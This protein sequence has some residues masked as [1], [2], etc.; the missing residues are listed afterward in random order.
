[1]HRIWTFFDSSYNELKTSKKKW[2]LKNSST[3]HK[4]SCAFCMTRVFDSIH[5]DFSFFHGSSSWKLKKVNAPKIIVSSVNDL[6]TLHLHKHDSMIGKWNYWLDFVFFPSFS[7]YRIIF[8]CFCSFFSSYVFNLQL[9]SCKH[10]PNAG[11]DNTMETK[12]VN[13]VFLSLVARCTKRQRAMKGLKHYL[14]VF[15]SVLYR[16]YMRCVGECYIWCSNTTII[17]RFNFHMGLHN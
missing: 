15:R 9:H 10:Q 17:Y 11:T 2:V 1:M 6:L 4:Q 7:F 3:V 14:R 16:K 12:C 13:I 8:L 5:N